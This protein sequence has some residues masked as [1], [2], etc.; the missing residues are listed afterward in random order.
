MD[1][2]LN[3]ATTLGLL[4][5]TAPKDAWT[6]ARGSEWGAALNA[7]MCAYLLVAHLKR[8]G[9]QGDGGGGD[10]GSD[11]SGGGGGGG[12]IHLLTTVAYAGLVLLASPGL[13]R[14][15]R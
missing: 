6:F 2:L 4:L 5:I 12:G 1:L 14:A 11:G 15:L 9:G 8:G 10:G 3:A 7:A 13:M